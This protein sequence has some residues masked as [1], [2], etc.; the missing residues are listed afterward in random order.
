MAAYVT[1]TAYYSGDVFCHRSSVPSS[2]ILARVVPSGLKANSVTGAVCPCACETSIS[3][4][5]NCPC[6][7]SHRRRLA[8][9]Q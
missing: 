1:L 4:E 7:L 2:L 8:P 3:L 5:E 9:L 6:H